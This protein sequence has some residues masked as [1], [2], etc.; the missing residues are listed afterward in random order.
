ML[1]LVAL[2]ALNHLLAAAPWARER[3]TPFAGHRARIVLPPWQFEFRIAADGTLESLGDSAIEVEIALPA[4][5]PFAA[6]Q[7]REALM[8]GVRVSGSAEF[9]E[10][11]S[12]VLRNLDWDAEEDLSRFVGDIAAHRLAQAA[13]TIVSAQKDAVRRAAE[14]LAEYVIHEQPQWVLKRDSAAL[15]AAAAD[16]GEKTDTLERRIAALEGRRPV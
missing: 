9:A 6:L 12:F 4:G 5:A 2:G 11:L 7:G 13:R 8:R 14:N 10:A 15:A 3:L 1:D 16:L